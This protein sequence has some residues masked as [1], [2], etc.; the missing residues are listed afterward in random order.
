MGPTSRKAADSNLSRALPQMRRSPMLTDLPSTPTDSRDRTIAA[1]FQVVRIGQATAFRIEDLVPIDRFRIEAKDIA[2]VVKTETY[3][4]A[5]F[6]R[7]AILHRRRRATLTV[8]EP[9]RFRRL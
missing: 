8:P 5:S 4:L 3:A 7:I 6:A 2:T 1:A 9:P